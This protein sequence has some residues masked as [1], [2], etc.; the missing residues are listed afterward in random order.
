MST[1]GSICWNA[2][3][4]SLRSCRPENW[5]GRFCKNFPARFDGYLGGTCKLALCLVP[6][7]RDPGDEMVLEAAV[8]ARVDALITHNERDFHHAADRFGL[9]VVTPAQALKFLKE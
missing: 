3:Y 2:V 8:N 1:D 4:M 5:S 7:L 6:Q 9:L